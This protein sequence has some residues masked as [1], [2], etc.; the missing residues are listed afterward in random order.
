MPT[1]KNSQSSLFSVKAACNRLGIGP[2]TLR[3][4]E[5]RYGAVEPRRS[6]SGQR[7]YTSTELDR[8]AKIIQLVNQGHGIGSVAKLSDLKLAKL[9]R[10]DAKPAQRPA[11]NQIPALLV[12]LEASL[13]KFDINHVSSLL[14]QKR[15][16]LGSRTFVLEILSHVLNWMGR[17]VDLN[18]MSVAHE[19][20]LS[21]IVRDQIYQTLRYGTVN[22]ATPKAPRVVLA[23][24]EGDLHEFGILMA[25][26][27]LSHYGVPIHLLGANLPAN[28]LALA[29]GAV[30]ADVVILGNAPVPDNERRVTFTQ[31]LIELH[32][33]LPKNTV[34]WIGGAGKL[35][36]LGAVMRGRDTLSLSSLNDLDI[37][38]ARWGKGSRI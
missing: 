19:H 10:Q 16:A 35:P 14:E 1:L 37:L 21:A 36:H 23:T 2:H 24:P 11:H 15:V 28:A 34:V 4:W 22:V 12:E 17:Q 3:A 6:N 25:A 29:A 5:T 30:H 31:Y 18:V 13:R 32:D 20:A 38:I 33:T 26:T 9:A 7:K 8:L 27:L